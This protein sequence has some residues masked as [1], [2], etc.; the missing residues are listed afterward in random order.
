MSPLAVHQYSR[1]R[2]NVRCAGGSPCSFLTAAYIVTTKT[3]REQDI[4]IITKVLWKDLVGKKRCSKLCCVAE[5]DNSKG[6]DNLLFNDEIDSINFILEALNL[7]VLFRPFC[8]LALVALENKPYKHQMECRC[9][10]DRGFP[11]FPC[12]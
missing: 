3:R 7:N 9:Q 1:S 11:Y 6:Y 5:K 2:A 8:F 12:I 4:L 10:T